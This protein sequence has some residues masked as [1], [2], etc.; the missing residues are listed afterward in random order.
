MKISI[1]ILAGDK[2]YGKGI[3]DT[4]LKIVNR[5][6]ISKLTKELGELG[7]VFIAAAKEQD[8]LDLDST[9]LQDGHKNIGPIEGLYNIVSN[10]DSEYIFVCGADMP[11]VSK[12]LVEYM[13]EFVCS[14]Y[15][16]YCL[17]DDNNIQP[18]CAIYS[19]SMLPSIEKAIENG[20]YKLIDLLKETRTKYI[21]LK[22][23]R[24]EDNTT[25]NIVVRQPAKENKPMAVFCVSGCKDTGK[26]GLMVK[27]INEFIREG[28][29]V[30]TIKH[31]GHEYTMDHAGTDSYRFSQAGAVAS[32]IFSDSQ[33]SANI[34]ERKTIEETIQYCEGVDV[35][36]IEG[37]KNSSYPKIEMLSQG[38]ASNCDPKTLI[39]QVTDTQSQ[40]YEGIPTFNWNDI[41]GIFSCIKKYFKLE[42]MI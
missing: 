31:D 25:K 35:V 8:Y 38:N 16:C 5:S 6:T 34:K 37:M 17:T 29:S 26:T 12:E 22:F 30:G 15:D 13:S 42:K 23:T 11:K 2:G 21:K 20:N 18:L 19:K 9:I 27:L 33:F 41:E 36:I 24:F 32:V 1:G 39:C 40:K 3:S 4:K 28:Y 14:D 10:A 7:Q